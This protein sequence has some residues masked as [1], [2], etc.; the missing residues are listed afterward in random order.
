M[1][2]PQWI[3]RVVQE[4]ERHFEFVHRNMDGCTQITVEGD[5]GQRIF[6]EEAIREV[7]RRMPHDVLIAHSLTVHGLLMFT[8]RHN[9][10]KWDW[11]IQHQE[12]MEEALHE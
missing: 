3:D 8:I 11:I 1:A 2:A 9:K 6:D 4:L 10:T 5:N 7:E 12:K